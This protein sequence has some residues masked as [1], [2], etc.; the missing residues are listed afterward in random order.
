[1]SLSNDRC[2]PT[3]RMRLLL[4]VLPAGTTRT[5]SRVCCVLAFRP[6]ILS[7]ITPRACPA[8]PGSTCKRGTLV[9][10]LE[11]RTRRGSPPHTSGVRKRR[12]TATCGAAGG[13][14]CL[15][16]CR[17]CTLFRTGAAG[18]SR[19]RGVVREQRRH[20][21]RPPPGTA[22]APAA[23]ARA[24]P[25]RASPFPALWPASPH[26]CPSTPPSPPS[27]RRALPASL[28]PAANTRSCWTA[29]SL[30]PAPLTHHHLEQLP[31]LAPPP[32]P[33]LQGRPC[34]VRVLP[35]SFPPGIC[36]LPHP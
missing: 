25:S 14:S 33:E 31:H 20:R 30:A 12:S 11:T 29:A 13:G 10:D 3:V 22:C 32:L 34:T 8:S 21:W 36:H 18:R 2:Y 27:N 15:G 23:A 35:G 9:P 6:T 19:C 24:P 17:C 4:L 5:T 16:G 7:P 1:M 28:P 26:S